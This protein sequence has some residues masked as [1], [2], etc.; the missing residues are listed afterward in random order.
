M[1]CYLVLF[2]STIDF[3]EKLTNLLSEKAEAKSGN[4][5]I[6]C[7]FSA[8]ILSPIMLHISNLRNASPNNFQNFVLEVSRYMIIF[9]FLVPVLIILFFVIML[10][11]FTGASLA[12]G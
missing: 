10:G 6:L 1:T 11:G 2:A 5:F 3:E 4:Y 8:S 9:F 12:V 7:W